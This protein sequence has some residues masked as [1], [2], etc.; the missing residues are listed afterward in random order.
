MRPG[1]L[2][3][4]VAL[5]LGA[6]V[7]GVAVETRP[8]ADRPREQ[9]QTRDTKR[10]RRGPK[11][12]DVD[13]AVARTTAV[14]AWFRGGPAP[15]HWT[16]TRP[17]AGARTLL[18]A[19]GAKS[20][21]SVEG[22][23]G[24]LVKTR[25]DGAA[26]VANATR[27]E[28]DVRGEVLYLEFL[29]GRAG[30]PRLHGGWIEAGRVSYVVQRAGQKLVADAKSRTGRKHSRPSEAW[31]TFCRDRPLDAAR[32][33]LQCFRSFV[34]GGYFLEDLDGHQFTFDGEQ[35][36]AVDA[37]GA[38]GGSPVG[39][40]LAW[41]GH[42]DGG[43]RATAWA[44]GM[45]CAADAECPHTAPIQS[46]CANHDCM[47]G[48]A[49]GARETRGWCRWSTCVGVDARAHA[50][51]LA[52]RTWA[53]PLILREGRFPSPAAKRQLEELVARMRSEAPEDRPSLV[54]ALAA[55]P[56]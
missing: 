56:G 40:V 35:V 11:I 23:R 48:F 15:R 14:A 7:D 30:V 44:R 37:P 43:P 42:A 25:N 12:S 5:L 33:L 26:R 31:S 4:T 55:L 24:V 22:R 20:A 50:Y 38:L 17:L 36:Y 19:G 45:V 29:R 2:L 53:L 32:A 47:D 13:H 52:T 10:A 6:R 46:R 34:E 21:F 8:V 41:L 39:P 16:V 54:D 49:V 27:D 28:I 1:V 9:H 3:L 18:G 51:D